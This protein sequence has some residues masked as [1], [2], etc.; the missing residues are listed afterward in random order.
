MFFSAGPARPAAGGGGPRHS[1]RAASLSLSL[2]HTHTSHPS[3]H[4]THIKP[5]TSLYNN[6]KPPSWLSHG[7]DLHLFKAGIE[8]KWEDPECE[9]GGK[10][11]V[12]VP[13]GAQ[14]KQALDTMWL[15]L[16][17]ACIGEQFAD[18]DEICGAVVNVRAKQDKVCLW[19][20]TAANEAAQVGV[21]KQLKAVLDLDS[22]ARVGFLVHADAKAYDRSAKDRYIV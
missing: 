17:L 16:L 20:R 21:A 7:S 1:T 12:L 6:I 8:P 15:N 2:T 9:A 13:K 5:T 3:P 22:A 14:S 10:W 4:R 11:T 18:G 19:T